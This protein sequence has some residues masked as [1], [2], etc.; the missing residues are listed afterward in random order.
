MQ[1]EI[2]G[3]EDDWEAELEE[4]ELE[5]DEPSLRVLKN[6]IILPKILVITYDGNV[7]NS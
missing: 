5:E 1:S 2:E 6:E 7:C 4:A 3:G